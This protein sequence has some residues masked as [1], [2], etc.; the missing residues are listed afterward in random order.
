VFLVAKTL[1]F[2]KEE[3]RGN[4]L[5]LHLLDVETRKVRTVRSGLERFTSL[6]SSRSG[7]QLVATVSTQRSSL[8]RMPV[9][10]GAAVRQ[11][12]RLRTS[13]RG[14]TSPRRAGDELL[15]LSTSEEGSGLWR[16]GSASASELWSP[17]RGSVR[18]G[19]AMEPGGSRIAFPVLLN[20]ATRL[21]MG[22][23]DGTGM[24]VLAPQLS[25]VGSPSW[26]PDRQWIATAAETGAGLRLFKIPVEG[27]EPVQLTQHHALD[28]TWSPQGA[29]IVY[30]GEQVGPNFDL[31]AVTANGEPH[32]IP[33]ITLP[34]GS[35]RTVF[36][37]GTDAAPQLFVRKGDLLTTEFWI[38]D[39]ASGSQRQLSDFGPEYRL[40]D[41]DLSPDGREIIFDRVREESDVVMIDLG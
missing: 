14:S 37:P 15:Y 27:G 2:L 28:P 10:A 41:F 40:G 38:I 11:A 3:S 33:R 9:S 18:G 25:V 7:Q 22:N 13:T 4:G 16:S 17:A 26:S 8:W 30:G 21:Y 6:A 5:T 29:F 32:T 19:V 31:A 24:R 23:A 12:E 1:A 34:R 36:L 20:G 35:S 39:F